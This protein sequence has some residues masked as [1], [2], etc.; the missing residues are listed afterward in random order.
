MADVSGAHLN[1]AVSI[2]LLVGK[3]ISIERFLI[4]IVAQVI[5]QLSA[6]AGMCA[7]PCLVVAAMIARNKPLDQLQTN[8]AC[9]VFCNIIHHAPPELI[10]CS[11]APYR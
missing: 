2:G 7:E 5:H 6:C 10:L 1:P 11:L 8:R 9:T 4:Y 3:R